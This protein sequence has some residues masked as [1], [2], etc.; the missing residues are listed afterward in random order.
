M[1]ADNNEVSLIA[2]QTLM[3]NNDNIYI[4]FIIS[5]LGISIIIDLI[6]LVRLR[7]IYLLLCTSPY[8]CLKLNEKII[9]VEWL[10]I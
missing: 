3:M 9:H 1:N 6:Y 2:M 5:D 4:I 8:L 7:V 10:L